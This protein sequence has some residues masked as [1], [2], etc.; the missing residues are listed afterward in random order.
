MS[1]EKGTVKT[2][3]KIEHGFV[4]V[5]DGFLFLALIVLTAS[6][7]IQI[8]CR[9][10]LKISSPW[11][12]ELARY[13]FISLIYVGSGRAF[14]N[15]GHINIDLM[16]SII[17]KKAKDPQKAMARFE[18]ISMILTLIFV[19]LFFI[20]YYQYLQ[21]ISRH[22]QTSASMH[23]NM[24]IPMSVILIGTAL[25]I[26]HCVCRLFYTYEGPQTPQAKE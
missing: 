5:E 16:D 11:C 12:E 4:K 14:I 9:Y 7:V 17:E 24:L 8:V 2:C 19:I 6:I 20:F 26:Y 23:I 25:M 22:P 1:N 3:R 18:K 15:G 10:I 21:A 13:L